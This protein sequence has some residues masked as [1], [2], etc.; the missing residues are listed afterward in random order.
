MNQ[1]CGVV[2]DGEVIQPNDQ[3]PDAVISKLDVHAE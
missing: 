1:R 3:E 2:C